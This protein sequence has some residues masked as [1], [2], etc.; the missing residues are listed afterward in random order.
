MTLLQAILCGLVA[1]YGRV[2]A[3]FGTLYLQRPIFLSAITGLILGDFKTGIIIGATLELFFMGAVSVGAYIPPD[4]VVGSVVAT[5]LSIVNGYPIEV[6]VTLAMPVAL[7]S[8]AVR[9]FTS[10]IE[11]FFLNKADIYADKCDAKGVVRM[12]WSLALIDCARRFVLTFLALYFGSAAVETIVNTIPEW[13]ITGMG[14]G[15][16]L[17]PALGFAMLMRMI[18]T[19]Q[20]LPYYFLGFVLAAYLTMPSLGVA[21]LAVIIVMVKFDFLNPNRNETGEMVN[22]STSGGGIDDDF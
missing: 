3:L 8:L 11:P 9:N 21:I 15:G 5:A 4:V 1:A 18:L 19:K 7:F 10:V 2:D 12:Q 20:I 13:I 16:G 17:M 14:A 22:S 6:A